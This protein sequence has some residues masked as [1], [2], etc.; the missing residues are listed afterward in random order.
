M[1][2]RRLREKREREIKRDSL[3]LNLVDLTCVRYHSPI[4]AGWCRLIAPLKLPMQTTPTTVPTPLLWEERLLTHIPHTLHTPYTY[5]T[6]T[7]HAR[8]HSKRKKR[9]KRKKEETRHFI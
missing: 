4:Q 9:K 5:H 6:H 3:I 1:E 2:N 8:T 7:I